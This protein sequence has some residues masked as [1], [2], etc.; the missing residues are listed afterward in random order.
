MRGTGIQVLTLG[1]DF[2]IISKGSRMGTIREAATDVSDVDQEEYWSQN[3]ALW[4]P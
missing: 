4:D 1:P 3:C 2:C